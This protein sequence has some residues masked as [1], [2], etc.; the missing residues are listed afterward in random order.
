MPSE[1]YWRSR[2]D[3]GF[4]VWEHFVD[5]PV[6][7]KE[8]LAISTLTVPAVHADPDGIFAQAM[9]LGRSLRA[10]AMQWDLSSHPARRV[11]PDNR[12]NFIRWMK[13]LSPATHDSE[14]RYWQ[15]RSNLAHED[16]AE[17]FNRIVE[18]RGG[19]LIVKP[20]NSCGVFSFDELTE[21]VGDEVCRS[22]IRRY[23]VECIGCQELNHRN[24]MTDIQGDHVCE[25]C[26]SNGSIEAATCEGCG[27]YFY[28]DNMLYVEDRGYYC[29]D[30]QPR[31]A[32]VCKPTHLAFE[33]PALC[34]PQKSIKNDEIVTVTVAH[35]EVS[36]V[37]MGEIRNL[38][39]KR[40][41]GTNRN[42][43]GL[44]LHE[45]ANEE[46]FDRTWQTKEGNFP[47]R[48]AKH[49]LTERSMKLTEEL[50]AEVGNIAK[51]YTSQT[52]KTHI[53]LTR[54]LNLPASQFCNDGS[55]WWTDYATS[56]CE[57]KA[58]HAFGVRGWAVEDDDQLD[59]PISRA[60]LIPLSVTATNRF[61][62]THVLPADA[63]VL[64]NAYGMEV[65]P[66]A[67]IVA[68]MTGKSYKKIAFRGD[69]MYVN[70]EVGVLIAEQ[71]VCDAVDIRDGILLP[72]RRT[73]TRC[74]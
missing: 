44:N 26:L 69:H 71:S 28:T 2:W 65:L 1:D 20:C 24:D 74:K 11:Y 30:H 19:D 62:P 45:L 63:Y 53:S 22:C 36:N 31:E 23:Y 49:M 34:T 42:Y 16:F 21:V 25:S 15:Q 60:W 5:H 56:R 73:C 43:D 18:L 39:Y 8:D 47:K 59:Q 13:R 32:S 40:T 29:S 51:A 27:T 4:L 17:I 9:R 72:R 55:C 50:M 38:I 6:S 54:N 12:S 67:R 70:G 37:G 61:G 7:S 64:F 57:A 35:G 10:P 68:G 33:F 3:S 52:G 46:T 41:G 14:F 66:F 48:L 58:Y